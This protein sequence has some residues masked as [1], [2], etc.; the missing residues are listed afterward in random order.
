MRRI[1]QL[2]LDFAARSRQTK[3]TLWW[4]AVKL[5][6]SSCRGC[7]LTTLLTALLIHAPQIKIPHP[8]KNT[9]IGDFL[10]RISRDFG[11]IGR[12]EVVRIHQ[13]PPKGCDKNV[14]IAFFICCIAENRH[15]CC[16]IFKVRFT[17]LSNRFRAV[18]LFCLR[19]LIACSLPYGQ[20]SKF[21]QGNFRFFLLFSECF[22]FSRS[23]FP[24]GCGDFL[25]FPTV[26]SLFSIFPFSTY[27]PTCQC[28]LCPKMQRFVPRGLVV[29]VNS[30]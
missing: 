12:H 30:Y 17:V 13:L 24:V 10:N 28:W 11:R 14:V 6:N 18:G 21:F 3:I 16:P 23:Q 9:W 22:Q 4:G 19:V 8:V 20:I 7:G 2:R 29:L 26:F 27:L 25:A 15:P 5:Q 1:L